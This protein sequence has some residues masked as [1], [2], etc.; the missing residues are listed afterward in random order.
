[1]VALEGTAHCVPTGVGRGSSQP[2]ALGSHEWA[3]Q[4]R[5]YE[6]P[7]PMRWAWLCG[8]AWNEICII[9]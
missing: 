9:L 1:M 6:N 2:R 3:L 4:V 7:V 8:S 5:K